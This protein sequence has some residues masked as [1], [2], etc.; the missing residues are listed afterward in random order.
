MSEEHM[1]HH[2]DENCSCGHEHHDHDHE[3]IHEH[4]HEH[5]H[6]HHDENCSCGHD[7]EHEHHDHNHDA[8]HENIE[9]GVVTVELNHH[10]SALVVSGKLTLSGDGDAIKKNLATQLE[11]AAARVSDLG[12]IVGH[13][14]ASAD[15]RRITMF[16]VTEDTVMVKPAPEQVVSIIMTAIIFAVD[17]DEAVKIVKDALDAVNS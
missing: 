1:H 17:D 7:H 6:H 11:A 16:S 9:Q 15:E 13:I 4:E 14:K 12:G 8:G 2:H 3:H 10:D 5:E